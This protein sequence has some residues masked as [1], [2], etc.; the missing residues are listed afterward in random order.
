MTMAWEPVWLVIMALA[1]A[2][3]TMGA[4]PV[5]MASRKAMK[6]GAVQAIPAPPEG[7]EP[8]VKMRSGA[9]LMPESSAKGT[10]W[11]APIFTGGGPSA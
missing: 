5:R 9:N 11:V 2:W 3:R 1:V 10:V 7:K 8:G 6:S 4:P